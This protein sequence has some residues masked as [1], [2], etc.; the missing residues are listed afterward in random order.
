MEKEFWRDSFTSLAS[1]LQRLEDV[2]RLPKVETTEYLQAAA[3]HYFKLCIELYWK[4]LKKVLAFEKVETTTPRD[5]IAKA[6]QFN[7]I[8]D[9]KVWLQMLD[10]RNITSHLYHKEKAK[11]VFER[12]MN[13]YWSVLEKNYIKLK[14]RFDEPK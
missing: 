5:A 4:A 11:I 12:I 8:D 13:I 1:T 7:L 14:A 10:D 6:Y 9:E 3:T 2:L